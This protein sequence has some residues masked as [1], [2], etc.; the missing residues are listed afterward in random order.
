MRSSL[1]LLLTFLFVYQ[2]TANAGVIDSFR[3]PQRLW[4]PS[5]KYNISTLETT[6]EVPDVAVNCSSTIRQATLSGNETH[7]FLQGV[8]TD[9]NEA[10]FD[11]KVTS[12]PGSLFT[13]QSKKS[14]RVRD[15]ENALHVGKTCNLNVPGWSQI[16]Y[17]NQQVDLTIPLTDSTVIKCNNDPKKQQTPAPTPTTTT[18][19]PTTTHHVTTTTRTTTTH[20]PTTTTT[21]HKPK[22][23]DNGDDDDDSSGGSANWI[24]GQVTFFTPNQGA[25]GDWNDDD[26]M[27][28][29]LGPAWYGNMN[30]E[31]KYCGEKVLITGP[32]GNSITV[33]VKDACPPCDRGHLD[34]SPAAFAKLGEFDTGI[35]KVKWHFL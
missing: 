15:H 19:V 4:S 3:A 26:D 27:I 10:C 21:T 9:S 5:N 30:A 24:N 35:L 33:T 32:R 20:R 31:S 7:L 29:A 23:T 8:S 18:V 22:P 28:V 17:K 1:L 12:R 6:L 14:S 34:L 2:Q 13:V 11:A 25:C 16:I